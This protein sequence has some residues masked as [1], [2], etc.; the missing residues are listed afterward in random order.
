[1]EALHPTRADLVR[2][3]D[4]LLVCAHPTDDAQLLEVKRIVEI[5]LEGVRYL[6]M[7]VGTAE[8]DLLHGQQVIALGYWAT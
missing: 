3:G 1:M 4:R 8:I 2:V 5:S 6:R 7:T